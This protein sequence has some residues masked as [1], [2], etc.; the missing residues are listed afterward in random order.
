MAG[1]SAG[2]GRVRRVVIT[3]VALF[4]VACGNATGEDGA[5]PEVDVEV[6]ATD[7][8]RFEPE[9]LQVSSGDRFALVCEP[10]VN[11]NLVI[12]ESGEQLAICRP[13]ET[14]VGSFDLEEGSYT[15]V[16]TVPG[17][18]ATMRGELNVSEEPIIDG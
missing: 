17:H 9:V 1:I 10:A 12:M 16:C 3:L 7:D 15:F 2:Q 8:L 14:D 11:H 4:A 13:G 6:R 5:V 18:S